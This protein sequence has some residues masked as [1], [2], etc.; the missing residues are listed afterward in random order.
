MRKCK[1]CKSK[2]EGKRRS[3]CS[4]E[5]ARDG[6]NKKRQSKKPRARKCRRCRAKFHPKRKGH[7]VC[8][9]ACRQAEVRDRAAR[10]SPHSFVT[11][12]LRSDMR[13]MCPDIADK[14][15]SAKEHADADA[16]ERAE[17]RRQRDEFLRGSGL[18]PKSSRSHGQ[19]DQKMKMEAE[20][21]RLT[22]QKSQAIREERFEEAARLR[23][24]ITKIRQEFLLESE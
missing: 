19:S 6:H 14:A 17:T 24:R 10:R 7:L 5:C 20:I 16:A 23:D 22:V 13:T 15:F 4:D 18:D 12:L 21:E 9:A 1:N 11:A 2:L 3:Y 8:S